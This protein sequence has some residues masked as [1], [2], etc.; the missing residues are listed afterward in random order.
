MKKILTLAMVVGLTLTA[1]GKDNNTNRE[2]DISK[3][4]EVVESNEK[5]EKNKDESQTKGIFGKNFNLTMKD[6]INKA[7]EELSSDIQIDEIGLEEDDGKYV[8]EISA[9][10]DK[11]EYSVKIDAENGN[12]LEKESEIDENQDKQALDF[13]KIISPK[14]AMEKA[15]KGKKDSYVESRSLDIQAK[16]T[17]Y[18][19]DLENGKDVHI[20][21]ISGEVIG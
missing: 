5:I 12:I 11:E 10:V 4:D 16:K 14:E 19:I 7:K 21:A 2:N 15:L 1:C 13:S 17:V 9:F 3:Q 20:D 8:Y 6:A 18:E